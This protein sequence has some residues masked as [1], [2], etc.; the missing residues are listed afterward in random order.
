MFQP[1]VYSGHR[2]AYG[3]LSGAYGGV[4]LDAALSAFIERLQAEV[5]DI[6]LKVTSGIRTAEAQ[7]SAMLTKAKRKDGGSTSPDDDITK[8]Y[9]KS[10]PRPSQLLASGRD[11]ATWTRMIQGWMDQGLY[12]SDHMRGDAIDIDDLNGSRKMTAEEV[13]RVAKAAQKLGAKVLLESMGVPTA[14]PWDVNQ[15]R[16]GVSGSHIHIE[17]IGKGLVKKAASTYVN[18]WLWSAA[19]G[20]VFL[21]GAVTYTKMKRK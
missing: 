1:S 11:L 20:S 12:L 15:I 9:R 19:L 17:D 8:L 18:W 3:S 4:V 7:A 6:K 2:G 5:P 10:E 16:P 13:L 21:L 14:G